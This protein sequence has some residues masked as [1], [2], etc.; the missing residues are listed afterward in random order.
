[1]LV[2]LITASACRTLG[3]QYSTVIIAFWREL[4][5]YF[6]LVSLLV[7]QLSDRICVKHLT[8]GSC[9]FT[10]VRRRHYL[11]LDWTMSLLEV[12]IGVL[13]D[14]VVLNIKEESRAVSLHQARQHTFQFE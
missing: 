8:Y 2:C 12:P 3:D 13:T 5:E 7:A 9:G 1:M 4:D 6:S 14:R 11:I 10:V